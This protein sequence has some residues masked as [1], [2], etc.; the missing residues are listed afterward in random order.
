MFNIILSNGKEI[1][2]LA[3]HLNRNVVDFKWVNGEYTGDCCFPC[4]LASLD[5]IPGQIGVAA[6][7]EL[8]TDTPV[9]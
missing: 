5:D 4:E 3:V 7:A 2:I 9:E 1:E 8:V 6:N